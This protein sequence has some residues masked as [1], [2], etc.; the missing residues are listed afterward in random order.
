[1]NLS[2]ASLVALVIVLA[3]ALAVPASARATDNLSQLAQ[4]T[5]YASDTI[6]VGVQPGT[7]RDEAT[8]QLAEAG[9]Q[10]I[11]YWPNMATAEAVPIAPAGTA[12]LLSASVAAAA[13][14]SLEASQYAAD[15]FRFVSL[16]QP[17]RAASLPATTTLPPQTEPDPND[18]YFD[19]QWALPRIDAVQSWNISHGSPNVVVGIIDS[20]YQSDHPDVDSAN[21]WHNQAEVDGVAGID[22]DGNGYVDDF[23]GWDWVDN[24]YYGGDNDPEDGY[25]HG[26]HVLGIVAAATNNEIGIA[27]L[28]RQIQVSPLR[29]LDNGGIGSI[30]GLIAALDYAVEMGFD[31]VNMSLTADSAN[32]GLADIVATAYDAGLL[33]VAAGGNCNNTAEY[34]CDGVLWPAAY[35]GA[36][37]VAST[38]SDDS[39]S[40]FSNHGSQIDVAAPG[41][42]ILSLYKGSKYE[43]YSGTSMAT[44]HVSA[45]LALLKSLRPDL[46]NDALVDIVKAT[47][48]D[49]NAAVYPGEDDYLGAGRI[50]FNDALLAASAGVDISVSPST[51]E[52]LVRG[53]S[54]N[55]E[56]AASVPQRDAVQSAQLAVI[57]STLPVEGAVVYVHLDEVFAAGADTASDVSAKGLTGPNGEVMLSVPSP[58]QTGDYVVTVKIGQ[59]KVEL[60]M[61]VV[62]TVITLRSQ[63][64]GAETT[65]FDF[66]VV[67]YDQS[68]NLVADDTAIS[69][70]SSIGSVAPSSILT[71]TDGHSAFTLE[72][73]NYYASDIVVSVGTVDPATNASITVAIPHVW[74]P[75]LR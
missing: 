10:L 51:L 49:V 72:V 33:I 14:D 11:A 31:I 68:G 16:D 57:E 20:G 56:V 30:S 25:G 22:D 26:T 6:L 58:A 28:G 46:D 67:V 64:L 75:S 37:A 70:I 21:I 2:R 55:I 44:P 12:G 34:P 1:M 69:V 48:E 41:G 73:P 65:E 62:G 18:E 35:D 39:H 23:V 29:V 53:R 3:A 13:V 47:A 71:T 27:G 19:E 17:I 15:T 59:S 45:L 8:D 42:N 40:V 5:D 74:V 63:V 32:D 24:K 9:L 36:V 4:D 52:P 38:N 61:T 43:V 7:T 60:P 66:D 54:F 50:N